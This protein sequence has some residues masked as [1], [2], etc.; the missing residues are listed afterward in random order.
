TIQSGD[1]SFQAEGRLRVSP[2]V[3]AD[4]D[5]DADSVNLRLLR[6]DWP[7]SHLGLR[8]SVELWGQE[9]RIAVDWNATLLPGEI[10]GQKTPAID[11]A[12]SVDERGVRGT[13]VLHERAIPVNI[14]FSKEETHALDFELRLKRTILAHSPRIQALG[15]I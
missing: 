9:G 10:A 14:S 5:L 2:E 13:F 15:P 3:E 11:A 12:G 8:S 1:A 7:E 4:F 6:E